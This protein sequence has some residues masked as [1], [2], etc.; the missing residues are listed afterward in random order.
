MTKRSLLLP[1]ESF[2]DMMDALNKASSP[3]ERK[4]IASDRMKANGWTREKEEVFR[5]N[6]ATCGFILPSSR[7]KPPTVATP[8]ADRYK[9]RL[10][11]GA[12]GHALRN[13]GKE[14][15]ILPDQPEQ[16]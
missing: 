1:G 3:E 6:A 10:P 8:I 15:E 12:V 5:D 2:N 7:T 4:R 16:D 11:P 9:T 13:E 14:R